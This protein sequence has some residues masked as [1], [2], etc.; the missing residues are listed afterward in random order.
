MDSTIFAW[1]LAATVFGGIQLFISKIVAHERRDSA[2]NGMM[3]YGISGAIALTILLVHPWPTE[4]LLVGFFGVASGAIHSI[5]NYVRIESLKY[6]DSVIYFPINKVLGPLLIVIAGIFWF[7]DSL[8]LQQ[9][10]GIAFSLSV[11]LLLLSAVEHHRQRNL[12]LGVIFLITST[13]LT[14]VSVLF[15]KEGLIRV[16]DVFFILGISQVAGTL[17]SASIM[18]KQ[19]GMRTMVAHID[20]RDVLLGCITGLLGFFSSFTLFEAIGRGY[21]SLVYVIHAHYILIP[22]VLSVWW[23]G[24]HINVRKMIAIVISCLAIILLYQ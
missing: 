12:R 10:I 19:K 2:F 14:S 5:G 6:I 22:I 23:Y 11:P 7:A 8:T 15:A 1:T 17:F 4:W 16:T 24:E 3:M 21:L 18:L 9:Y 20:R 13:V